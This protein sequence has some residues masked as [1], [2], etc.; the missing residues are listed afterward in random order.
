MIGGKYALT[1]FLEFSLLLFFTVTAFSW[2]LEIRD[3]APGEFV[4]F[5]PTDG[6]PL[7]LSDILSPSHS[8]PMN[9]VFENTPA[10]LFVA[11]LIGRALSL[12]LIILHMPRYFSDEELGSYFLAMCITH[13]IASIIELGRFLE[14]D[15]HT[16]VF[17][18]RLG[19]NDVPGATHI[20]RV[21][22]DELWWRHLANRL[23]IYVP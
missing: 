17:E 10:A 16:S 21:E 11:H 1:P 8:L 23:K 22:A 6:K 14:D 12:G 20:L 18:K 4:A 13:L 15:R 9:R 19:A 3:V 5:E 2:A 7:K